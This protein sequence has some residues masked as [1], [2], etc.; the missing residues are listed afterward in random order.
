MV[1]C[2]LPKVE[3]RVRFS[4]PA[5]ELTEAEVSKINKKKKNELAH[6]FSF[7]LSCN[8]FYFGSSP[9]EESFA[10]PP[11]FTVQS[12]VLKKSFRLCQ[13]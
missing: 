12:S 5:P 10:Y 7:C 3:T 6:S 13:L 11:D 8:D 2:D 9:C 1:E 4:L